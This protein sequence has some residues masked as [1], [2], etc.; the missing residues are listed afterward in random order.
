MPTVGPVPTPSPIIVKDVGP[1]MKKIYDEVVD[2]IR[3]GGKAAWNNFEKMPLKERAGIIAGVAGAGTA[4][5]VGS[6]AGAAAHAKAHAAAQP[7]QV[8]N[9]LET[10]MVAVTPA[11][12]ANGLIARYSV[13][14]GKAIAPVMGSSATPLAVATFIL[15]GAV[16]LGVSGLAVYKLRSKKQESNSVQVTPDAL[17]DAGL[18]E[19]SP[20]LA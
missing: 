12:P 2:K 9:V 19:E 4:I 14:G 13:D 16:F 20:L 3:T 5:V 17:E 7:G 6:A 18:V 8:V 10:V 1:E 11:P 15:F